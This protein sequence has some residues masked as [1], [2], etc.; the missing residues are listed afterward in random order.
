MKLIHLALLIVLSLVATAVA[1]QRLINTQMLIEDPNIEKISIRAPNNPMVCVH[2]GK[3]E[4]C[5]PAKKIKALSDPRCD[6]EAPR[7]R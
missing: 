2:D 3:T 6:L 1:G 4:Y 5:A 7:D